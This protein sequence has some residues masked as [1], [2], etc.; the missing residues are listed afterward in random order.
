MTFNATFHPDAYADMPDEIALF[1]QVRRRGPRIDHDHRR[2]EYGVALKAIRQFNCSTVL[3]VGASNAGFTVMAAMDGRDVFAIDSDRGI[4]WLH[5]MV[6]LFPGKIDYLEQELADF[7]GGEFDAVCALSVI[8]HVKDDAEFLRQLASHAKKLIVLTTDFSPDGK[9]KVD[10]HLRTYSAKDLTTL[11]SGLDGWVLLDTPEWTD[12]GAF[13]NDYNFASVVMVRQS[14]PAD[15]EPT[16]P[17]RRR[18]RKTGA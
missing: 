14:E 3:D 6:N 7:D 12:K 9:R 13:V 15:N 16:K 10:G 18:T 1:E 11:T 2:W 5:N 4:H 8:E 17:T